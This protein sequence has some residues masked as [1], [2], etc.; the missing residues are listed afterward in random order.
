[1][2]TYILANNLKPAVELESMSEDDKRSILMTE[3]IKAH[4]ME[5]SQLEA[6]SNVELLDMVAEEGEG[7]ETEME[8]D[9]GP[10]PSC[11]ETD[12]AYIGYPMDHSESGGRYLDKCP[13]P[14]HCQMTCQEDA[15]CEWFN[16][17]N[18]TCPMSGKQITKC[19]MKAGKGN[20][21][22]M[23]G[24]I[25]G[26][27][28]CK[29]ERGCIERDRMYIGD[30]LSVWQRRKNNFGRQ[31]SETDCQDLCRRT[32]YCKWFNWNKNSK[33]WL[34]KSHGQ[35]IKASVRLEPGV[36][37]GPRECPQIPARKRCDEG[38]KYFDGKCY[39]VNLKMDT[40]TLAYADAL[41][42]CMSHQAFL[43][44]LQSEEEYNFVTDILDRNYF[45]QE[46]ID[47]W[48]GAKRPSDDAGYTWQEDVTSVQDIIWAEG[49]PLS[50]NRCL[51]LVKDD[52]AMW[53]YETEDCLE[54]DDDGSFICEKR[55]EEV[56]SGSNSGSGSGPGSGSE[57]GSGSGSGFGYVTQPQLPQPQLPKP[58][59]PQPQLPQPQIPQPLPQPLSPSGSGS[60]SGPGSASAPGS[61]SGSGSGSGLGSGNGSGSGSG[62]ES[63]SGSGSI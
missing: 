1:M 36:S 57:S 11:F 54:K 2:D 41:A 47:F 53:M 62:S 8:M 6:M 37:T 40:E 55:A 33:C 7:G 58:Q 30:P 4:A 60:G 59:L 9:M 22:D 24:V 3:L 21:K 42:A 10:L 15:S 45:Q 27:K 16:W 12:K 23:P 39:L 51:Q 38:W 46:G 49:E 44:S 5:I 28:Y 63:G 18:R 52:Y 25:T 50:G 20:A 32:K 29:P 61:G 34:K 14:Q 19:W 31:K 48:V 56:G 43:V 26:P 13:N 35:K 17:S